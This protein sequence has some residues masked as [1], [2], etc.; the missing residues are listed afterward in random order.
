[1]S[2][3]APRYAAG[4]SARTG[5]ASRILAIAS[6]EFFRRARAATLLSVALTFFV[7]VTSVV[8][9]VIFASFLRAP[10]AGDFESVYESP[11]WPFLMLIVAASAGA[12]SLAEDVG[13]R[14]ISLYLSRP[15]RLVDY[16]SAK[17]IACG[18]WLVIATVGP[19][20]TAVAVTGALGYASA[21]VLLAAL[22]GF[23]ATG[24]VAAIFFT[25]L[26]LALSSLTNRALYS[27]VA[28]FG[29]ILVL[30]IGGSVVAG[31]TGNIYVPYANPIENIRSVAHGAFGVSGGTAT[32]PASSALTL[33][34]SGVVLW[35]FALWR[36]RR[37]EVVSE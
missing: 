17:T 10:T 29:V 3:S 11:V 28:I 33:V 24:F 22:L 27:G 2:I 31:I 8:V 37:V 23:V 18:S 25:G 20:L 14:S 9:T 32:D 4:P 7:V 19:G 36:M 13:D 34:G 15:I 6:R 5:P 21:S 1:V 26:A 35:V 12:G 16:V 30:Y